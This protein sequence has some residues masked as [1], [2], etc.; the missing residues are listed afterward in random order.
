MLVASHEHERDTLRSYHKTSVTTMTLPHHLAHDHGFDPIVVP[1]TEWGGI[2][3][4]DER[5]SVAAF[6]RGVSDHLAIVR[7]VV[8]D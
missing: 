3:G 6:R 8:Y 1:E 5:V 2:H 7:A 4:N